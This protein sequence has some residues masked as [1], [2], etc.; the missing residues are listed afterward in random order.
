[1][2]KS[3]NFAKN[4]LMGAIVIAIIF[5]IGLITTYGMKFLANMS[6]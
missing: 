2:E 6:K 1:M 4:I 3:K 5:V